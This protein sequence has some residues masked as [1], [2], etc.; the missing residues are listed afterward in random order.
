MR[1]LPIYFL[2]DVSESMV[3]EPIEH[4]QNGM[5][6]IIQE[7]RVDPYA[8]ETVFVSV[9][10]FAG[11]AQCLSPL[12]ELYKFYPPKFPIG[13]GT[14][15]GSGLSYLMDDLDKS[16]QKTN[17]EIKGD[18]KPIIF[19]FTD[20]I[21]TDNPSSA[22][23]R[24]QD[25]YSKKCNLVCVSLGGHADVKILRQLTDNVLLLK[26]TDEYSFKTFFKWITASIKTNSVSITDTGVDGLQLASTNGINL[27]KISSEDPTI[28]DENFA[29]L[30][31]KCSYTKKSYL[32][33]YRKHVNHVEGLEYLGLRAID[34]KLIGAYS[35]DEESYNNL[36]IDAPS[37]R[38]INTLSLV[39]VP[40][41]PCCG[42]QYGIVVCVCGNLMCSD[43][44]LQV[45]P[46]CG[47]EGVLSTSTEGINIKR[48]RG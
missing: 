41:C 13:D 40:T 45:C 37:T 38:N 44:K 2:I 8:L 26:D 15:L 24:W 35:L 12:T 20:G 48:V 21:P 31:S 36:S 32:I 7:L 27:E 14:S 11:K 19:L 10:V 1:R 47:T 9:I 28:V 6:N 46:W 23:K 22:I 43:G 34:Y 42:S 25:H 39:G 29:V 17:T 30:R 4:V 3:G 18:W 5:R 16:I 33:K